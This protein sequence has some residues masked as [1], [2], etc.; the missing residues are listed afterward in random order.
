MEQITFTARG[1]FD[2]QLGGKLRSLRFRTHEL[3]KLESRMGGKGI[4]S[5]LDE[6]NL[7]MTFLRDAIIVGVAH[8]FIGKKGKQREV[9]TEDLVERWIDE[10]E[11]RDGITFE[12]LLGAIVTGV[13]QGLPGAKM[14]SKSDEKED[15]DRPNEKADL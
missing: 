10:S 11:E 6:G 2:I 4:F 7:G 5:I 13:V 8:E 12:D 9:L 14:A 3:T 15:E 1:R